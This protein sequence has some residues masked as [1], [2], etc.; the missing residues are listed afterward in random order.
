MRAIAFDEFGGPEVLK[1]IERPIPSPGPGE[2][3]VRVAASTVNPTD[4]MMRSGAQAAL[5]T[6]LQPP[7]IAGM[8]FS[9]VVH[10]AGEGAR[11]APGDHVIGVVN[12]R[13]AEGGAY[14]EY[15]RAPAASVAAIPK[16]VDLPGAA[17]FPMN[18][19][20]ALMALEL[21]ALKPGDSVLITGGTGMLGGSAIQL[22]KAAG[23]IVLASGHAEDETLLKG[24]G[25]LRVVPRGAG[26]AQAVRDVFPNGVGGLI[27]GAL[28]G[29]EV[30]RAVR[31]GGVAVSLRNT[32]PIEDARL[33]TPY[34]S[35][36]AGMERNDLLTRISGLIA[37]EALSLRIA[38]DGIIPFAQ[39][40][41]AHRR[42]E[43]ERF[44]GRLVLQFAA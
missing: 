44:R 13:R 14:A 1:V 23:L 29:Q 3:V 31:D 33:S 5:M 7:Y 21:L 32:H 40:E 27:D 16:T 37:D 4:L 41:A 24:L 10:A 2:V 6:E 12:P 36:L 35:V 22:A 38:P 20:T 26:L 28:I 18:A 19:L 30:S 25:A 8:E 9:G 39:A 17:T 43:T 34:V 15:L 42:A 11:V